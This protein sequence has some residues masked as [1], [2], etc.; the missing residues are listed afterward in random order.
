MNA[1]STLLGVRP[2]GNEFDDYAPEYVE[3]DRISREAP[4]YVF[5]P[6]DV[7]EPRRKREHPELSD[8]GEEHPSRCLVRTKG[9][10]RRCRITPLEKWGEPLPQEMMPDGVE[11]Y[12][13]V[14]AEA[15]GSGQLYLSTPLN[16]VNF[17]RL[18]GE[19]IHS[20]TGRVGGESKGIVELT[21]C[22]GLSWAEFEATGWQQHFFPQYPHS[23]WIPLTLRQ[24]VEQI[25]AVAVPTSELRQM[26]TEMLSACEEFR[27]WATERVEIEN[28]LLAVGTVAAGWTWRYSGLAET[29][30]PQLELQRKDE[31]LNTQA[32]RDGDLHKTVE[33]VLNRLA[34]KGQDSSSAMELVMKVMA[35]MQAQNLQ[36]ISIFMTEQRAALAASQHEIA[37][38]LARLHVSAR[39]DDNGKNKKP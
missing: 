24:I 18:P 38:A 8:G 14:V 1:P 36:T 19:E 30:M 27:L 7:L 35:D 3:R 15:H 17:P 26:Q 39:N 32:R 5:F 37:E 9:Y 12:G 20:V 11:G 16:I 21:P 29:L 25:R 33:L 13:S 6:G 10:L 34:D 28:T 23:G 4:R 2:S 22:I 31:Y